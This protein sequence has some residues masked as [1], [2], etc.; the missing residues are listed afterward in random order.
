M[1]HNPIAQR[2]VECLIRKR[3]HAILADAMGFIQLRVADHGW[4]NIDADYA[5][6]F[7]SQQPDLAAVCMRPGAYVNHTRL[8]SGELAHPVVK[9]HCAI[10]C[11]MR[12]DASD[13]RL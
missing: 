10:L 4:I 2:D 6:D 12:V 5:C 13:Y 8:S 11:P 7:A 1:F 9:R 3:Q